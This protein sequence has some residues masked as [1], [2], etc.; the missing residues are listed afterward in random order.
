MFPIPTH[1]LDNQE[2][3]TIL[4]MLICPPRFLSTSPSSHPPN[5]PLQHSPTQYPPRLQP[6]PILCWCIYCSSHLHQSSCSIICMQDMLGRCH[7]PQCCRSCPVLYTHNEM[8]S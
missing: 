5:P 4:V 6:K 1:H 3:N 8:S 7:I 2:Q